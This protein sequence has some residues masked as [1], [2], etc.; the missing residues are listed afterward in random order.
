MKNEVIELEWWTVENHKIVLTKEA[1]L[2]LIKEMDNYNRIYTEFENKIK[3]YIV[4]DGPRP[5]VKHPIIDR[6]DGE[7]SE[8]LSCMLYD[9]S[10]LK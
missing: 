8:L 1:P 9:D 3:N 5:N 6:L 7:E 4:Y 10:Y 2:W